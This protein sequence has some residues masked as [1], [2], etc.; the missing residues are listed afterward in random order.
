MTYN[1]SDVHAAKTYKYKRYRGLTF[2][3]NLQETRLTFFFNYKHDS[4]NFKT[5]INTNN[6]P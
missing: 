6:T 1:R 4:V 3:T 5:I 2:Y